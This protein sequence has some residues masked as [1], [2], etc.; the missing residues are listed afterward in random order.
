MIDELAVYR[1]RVVAALDQATA[2]IRSDHRSLETVRL[3]ATEWRSLVEAIESPR[4]VCQI[5]V[6]KGDAQGLT[7]GE[8]A[9]RMGGETWLQWAVTRRQGYWPDWFQ[10]ALETFLATH[11]QEAA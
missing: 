4:C 3:G 11:R 1:A 7:L 2:S 8:V 6:P 9:D 5:R 10:V